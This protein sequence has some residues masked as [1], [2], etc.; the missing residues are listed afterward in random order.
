M[1]TL[2]QSPDLVHQAMLPVDQIA[3]SATNPRKRI[4]DEM[5]NELAASIAK[6]G[7]LQ[8]ILVRPSPGTWMKYEI[9]A[10]ECRHR[11]AVKAGLD[12]I[13]AT[14]RDLTDLEALELQVLE[15]LHRND[16]HPMEEAEGFRQL[17]DSNGYT[18]ANLAEKIGKSKAYVY[19]S[20]KLCELCQA[21]RDAFFEGKLTASTALLIARIPGEKLQRE[22]VKRVTTPYYGGDM[23]S[24]RQ[25][26][27]L[28]QNEFTTN[29][30]KAIFDETDPD[31]VSEAGSCIDCPKLSGNSREIFPDIKSADV[32]TD[33][34]CFQIKRHAHI[35]RLK[36]LPDTI[37][38]EAALELLPKSWMK[39]QSPDYA[40]LRSK[41]EGINESWEDLLGD[42]LPTRT[43][44]RNDEDD[45]IVVVDVPAA[46]TLLEE[47]GIQPEPEK[48]PEL[49]PYQIE[50]READAA[51]KVELDRRLTLLTA[52]HQSFGDGATLK[53]MLTIITPM[54]IA[55]LFGEM[56]DLEISCLFS[57]RGE[58]DWISNLD[59]SEYEGRISELFQ[60]DQQRLLLELFA[61]TTDVSRFTPTY[62]WNPDAHKLARFEYILSAA[63]IDPASNPGEIPTDPAS[64]AHADEK[65]AHAEKPDATKTAAHAGEPDDEDQGQ[66]PIQAAGAA[67]KRAAKKPAAKTAAEAE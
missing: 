62:S 2:I 51:R 14:I 10:G 59:K 29:L 9:V 16:L 57:A 43:I 46:K 41:P 40:N 28:I 20:L 25:A 63:G 30:E 58:E 34:T 33:T 23:P 52:F 64:A 42:E 26:V 24:Y 50:R 7:V 55:D 18:A 5:I 60:K 61:M 38:G 27:N 1:Q 36:A 32:C 39:P 11:A 17:L 8:P 54:M 45:P 44:I 53:K 13:P 6:V 3:S 66:T 22:A 4:T 31:L 21:G 65:V 35:E 67:A 15:N 48:E 19:A 47:K 12:V 56:N 37:Q 49:S